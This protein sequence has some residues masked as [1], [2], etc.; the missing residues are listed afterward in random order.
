MPTLPTFPHVLA[1]LQPIVPLVYRAMEGA[2]QKTREFFEDRNVEVDR[3]LAPNLVRYFA[4]EFLVA[5]GQVVIE[6]EEADTADYELQPLPNN[7]LCLSFG[8]HEI[9]IL[10]S[11]DGELPAPG[12]SKSRQTFWNWNGQQSFNFSYGDEPA[13]TSEEEFPNL[14]LIILWDVAPV[15]YTLKKLLLGCPTSGD[16]TKESVSAYFLE[17]IPHP[18]E[19]IDLAL[20]S[21]GAPVLDDL[22]LDLKVRERADGQR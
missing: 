18:I 2:L 16:T 17:E 10:K 5:E 22:D 19:A 9:R 13:S 21:N 14:H 12:Q 15:K 6:E 4:K 11:D 1:Q 7:G 20:T 8:R 3:S